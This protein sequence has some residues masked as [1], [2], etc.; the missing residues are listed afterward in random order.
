MKKKAIFFL[1]CVAAIVLTFLSGS[2][3]AGVCLASAG[4]VW[5][6]GDPDV[7]TPA[8]GTPLAVTIND[9]MTMLTPGTMTG[10]LTINL[11]ITDRCRKGAILI[12]RSTSDGTARTIT[13]GTGFTAVPLAG[14]ISKTNQS[15]YIYDGTTFV[16][17]GAAALIN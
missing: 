9:M 3:E 8:Y 11:T 2:V 15:L 1:F 10:A 5:P 12:I 13:H 4:A 16:Q 6:Y 17:V 7:Q 14:T